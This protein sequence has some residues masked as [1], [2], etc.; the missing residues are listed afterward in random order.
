[1]A[2]RPLEI[3]A[4]PRRPLSVVVACMERSLGHATAARVVSEAAAELGYGDELLQ[5]EALELLETLA[6]HPGLVGVVARFA[7]VRI[8]L[9]WASPAG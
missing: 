7:A 3:D 8:L 6:R 5:Q 4:P 1:M 2:A 9:A